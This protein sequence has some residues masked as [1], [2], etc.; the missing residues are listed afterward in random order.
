M[1]EMER[2]PEFF[3]QKITFLFYYQAVHKASNLGMSRWHPRHAGRR[4]ML[5]QGLEQ[6]HEIPDGEHVVFHEQPQVHDGLDC[7]RQ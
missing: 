5:L 6:Q 7:L 2:S 3:G 1:G 4:Q